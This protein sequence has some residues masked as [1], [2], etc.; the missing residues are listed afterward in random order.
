MPRLLPQRGRVPSHTP[1]RVAGQGPSPDPAFPA[2]FYTPCWAGQM[3]EAW[4][5][6]KPLCFRAVLPTAAECPL[7][8]DAGGEKSFQEHWGGCR[9]VKVFPPGQPQFHTLSML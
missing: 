7:L 3:A 4:M 5:W 6:T 1:A 9:G 8:R 2:D